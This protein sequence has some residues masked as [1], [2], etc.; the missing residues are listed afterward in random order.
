MKNIRIDEAFTKEE[1]L[2]RQLDHEKGMVRRR[3]EQ[4]DDNINEITVLRKQ[5]ED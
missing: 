4:N 5:I 2:R 3:D 1:D